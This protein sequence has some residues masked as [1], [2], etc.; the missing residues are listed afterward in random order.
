MILFIY[1]TF[2]M[3]ISDK[4]TTSSSKPVRSPFDVNWTFPVIP[5]NEI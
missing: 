5:S 3:P 4:W 2:E 1:F